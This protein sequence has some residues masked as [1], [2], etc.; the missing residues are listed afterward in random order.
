MYGRLDVMLAGLSGQ[1][2]LCGITVTLAL[3]VFLVG[4]LNSHLF[5]NEILAIHTC[6]GIVGGLK[7]RKRDKTIAFREIVLI[8][9]NLCCNKNVN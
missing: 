5:I 8:T 1:H 2:T 7:V 4:V 9:R 6:N 3:A